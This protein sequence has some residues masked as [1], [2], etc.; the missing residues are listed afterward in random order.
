MMRF[1]QCVIDSVKS[2]REVEYE[3]LVEALRFGNE[4]V[5]NDLVEGMGRKPD[6][7][8]SGEGV[9]ERKSI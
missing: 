8:E 5:I 3:D 7:M 4:K 1:E 6:W 2:S 9:E